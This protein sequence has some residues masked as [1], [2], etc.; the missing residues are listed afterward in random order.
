MQRRCL[1]ISKAVDSGDEGQPFIHERV[2]LAIFISFRSS[3]DSFLNL[4]QL[5]KHL[6]LQ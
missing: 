6:S 2:L 1:Y 4:Q 5:H 3:R